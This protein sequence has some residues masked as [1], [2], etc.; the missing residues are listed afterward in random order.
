MVRYS[1]SGDGVTCCTSAVSEMDGRMPKSSAPSSK[2]RPAAPSTML[3]VIMA[4]GWGPGWQSCCAC[5]SPV[6]GRPGVGTASHDRTG[7]LGGVRTGKRLLTLGGHT[8]HAAGVWLAPADL[9]PV[10][11]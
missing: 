10:V 4:N 2:N 11:G 9:R 8:C 6:D 1:I 7:R 3:G 5:P